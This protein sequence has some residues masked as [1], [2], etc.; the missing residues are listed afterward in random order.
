[1]EDT[2]LEMAAKNM[3][4]TTEVEENKPI[5][6]TKATEENVSEVAEQVDEQ[7]TN[8]DEGN[9]IL[10]SINSQ[11]GSEYKSIDDL[12]EAISFKDK[13]T[14][15]ED[16]LSAKEKALLEKDELVNEYK[17]RS[18]P[19]SYFADEKDYV[20]S[21]VLKSNPDYSSEVVNSIVKG[22]VNQMSDMEVLVAKEMLNGDVKNRAEAE[23]YI[24]FNYNLNRNT[25]ELDESERQMV[26]FSKIK[27]S[28]EANIARKEL[29]KLGSDIEI[30][31]EIDLEKAKTE[32]Q[33]EMQRKMEAVRDEW[34][35]AM[36]KFNEAIKD[37][38]VKDTDERTSEPLTVFP[39]DEEGKH[40]IANEL[41]SVFVDR[42]YEPTDENIA[43]FSRVLKENYIGKNISKIMKTFQNDLI[44]KMKDEEFKKTN[45]PKLPNE[46]Q[47]QED[48]SEVTLQDAV[49]SLF[50]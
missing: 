12:K 46:T 43:T 5:E 27:M 44:S 2:I 47:K 30:P 7:A 41:K 13:Y 11:L 25:E 34:Q 50:K 42:G 31:S 4:T 18:N 29:S 21:Q 10:T 1:M 36:P 17:K 23:K 33:A 6:E 40:Y 35:K 49:V 38:V 16:S 39:I 9:D 8:T 37:I 24:N 14:E 48:T 19:L 15:L 3:G 26:E 32:E 22:D 45:N 20:V 28:R